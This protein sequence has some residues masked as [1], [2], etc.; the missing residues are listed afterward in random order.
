MAVVVNDLAVGDGIQAR[1]GLAQLP[2]AAAG[3]AGNAEDLP[4][5]GGEA[6]VIQDFYA[7]AVETGQPLDLQAV[8]RV[9]GFGAVDVQGDGV[10]DHHVGQLLGAGLAGV[11][12]GDK[13]ALA[14]HGDPVGNGHDLVELVGDDD[15]GLPVGPHVPQHGE[16][17]LRLLGGQHGGRLVQDQDVCA[18]V[19]D[20]DD[21]HRL[22]L[23]DGHVVD[24]LVRV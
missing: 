12:R 2:L 24:L 15:D 6:H 8:L 19:E 1:N 4:A 18:P 5:L 22:L 21:L 17:L 23:G 9:L 16:E 11:H 14:Q 13:L 20:L 3:D 10:A 7:L